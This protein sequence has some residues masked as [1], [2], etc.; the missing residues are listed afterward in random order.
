[1]RTKRLKGLK[2]RDLRR[3]FVLASHLN[4]DDFEEEERQ[5]D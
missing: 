3:I 2:K 5:E 1:M 4:P